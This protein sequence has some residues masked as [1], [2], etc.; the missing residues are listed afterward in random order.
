[1][2]SDLQVSSIWRLPG[3]LALTIYRWWTRLKEVSQAHQ[4]QFVPS[5]FWGT[6]SGFCFCYYCRCYCDEHCHER[7]NRA[8][9]IKWTGDRTWETVNTLR[10]FC[11]VYVMPKSFQR[12]K[13]VSWHVEI[14]HDNWPVENDNFEDYKRWELMKVS[15]V[16]VELIASENNCNREEST[17]WLSILYTN[18]VYIQKLPRK[19]L[20]RYFSL[21]IKTL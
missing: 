17:M 16:E 7:H 9:I 18:I 20:S 2:I 13:K 10:T 14:A 8:N 1:M 6:Y 11:L 21:L 19:V 12:M 5:L 3:N 4:N 15:T